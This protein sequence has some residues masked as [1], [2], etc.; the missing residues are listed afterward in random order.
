MLNKE[1]EVIGVS[2]HLAQELPEL[3]ELAR[4][5]RLDLGAVLTRTI[6]LD[7][8]AVNDALDELER[9][10]DGVRTVIAL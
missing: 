3:I 1:A 10:G 8:Q 9:F 7:A 2:D 6:A 5:G 4:G